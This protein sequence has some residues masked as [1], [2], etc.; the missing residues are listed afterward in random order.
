[1]KL[2]IYFVEENPRS[3]TERA[4]TNRNLSSFVACSAP[5]CLLAFPCQLRHFVCLTMKRKVRDALGLHQPLR[6]IAPA[7]IHHDYVPP[8][9][10]ISGRWKANFR[11]LKEFVK[12]DGHARMPVKY[13]TPEL[14]NVGAWVHQQRAAFRFECCGKAHGAAN[15]FHHRIND[16]QV[17]LLNSLGF[18]WQVKKP[19]ELQLWLARQVC[20]PAAFLSQTRPQSGTVQSG[21]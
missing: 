4:K 21:H 5:A 13:G 8:R 10:K 9:A 14:P 2:I 15:I 1:M 17:A 7:Q 20:N 18:E 11:A 12:T 16:K 6:P 3:A 19:R